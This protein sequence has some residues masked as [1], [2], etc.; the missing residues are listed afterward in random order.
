VNISYSGGVIGFGVGGFVGF[1][2]GGEVGL[3][4]GGLV[5]LN[6][7]GGVGTG[8]GGKVGL[9]VS[10]LIIGVSVG[11][12]VEELFVGD[13]VGSCICIAFEVS[14]NCRVGGFAVG[15]LV[16]VLNGLSGLRRE[17]CTSFGVVGLLFLA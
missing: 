3:G 15:R 13:W 16:A 12:L 2:V 4:V 11:V 14:L 5:G 1:G 10:G 8:V 9:D 17:L 6:V 7:G